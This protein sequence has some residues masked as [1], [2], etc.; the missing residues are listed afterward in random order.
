LDRRKLNPP[1]TPVAGRVIAAHGR[2]FLVH[3]PAGDFRCVTRGRKSD[4]VCGDVVAITPTSPDQGVIDSIGPRASHFR[5]ADAYRSKAIAANVTQVAIV[6]APRP[7][8][9]EELLQRCLVAAGNQHLPAVIVANKADLAEHA[10]MLSRLSAYERLGYAVVPLSARADVQPLR[11]LLKNHVTLLVGQS[12]MGKSTIIHALFPQADVSIEAFS[13]ALDSGRHTTTHSRL[14]ALD[15]TSAI[16]DSPGLQEFALSHLAQADI[17][18]A[19]PDFR[20]YRGQC[21]FRN[22]RHQQEPGCALHQAV[23]AGQVGPGRLAF[24]Q[25]LLKENEAASAI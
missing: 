13:E 18:A 9:S 24:F 22:C 17:E 8:W 2:H 25:R 19:M 16:I 23:A 11:R 5:R 21:R 15:E 20:P 1:Q 7:S 12:G 4:V 3:T 10:D 14:Y 6:V